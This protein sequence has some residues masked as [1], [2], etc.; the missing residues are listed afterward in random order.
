MLENNN[1]SIGKNFIYSLFFVKSG[2]DAG[3]SFLSRQY[4]RLSVF[5]FFPYVK[6]VYAIYKKK[7]GNL[8]CAPL[9]YNKKLGTKV[10][11]FWAK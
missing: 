9:R 5:L 8:M 3:M 7:Q 6:K 4:R 2:S 11:L 1:K 10:Y